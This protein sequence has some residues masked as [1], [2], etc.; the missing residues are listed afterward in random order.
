[1]IKNFGWKKDKFDE[2]DY[3][4]KPKVIKL[5]DK[6]SLEGY[7]PSV[8]DQGNLGSCTG[9]GIGGNLTGISKR[10]GMYTEWFS[11]VWIYNG[12]RLYGGTLGR[13]SGAYPRDC[14]E[15]LVDNGSLLEHFHPYSDKLDVTDPTKWAC[16]PEAK[17]YPVI[18]YTRIIGDE[19]SVCQALAEGH[20]VSLG[21]PWFYSWM[22]TDSKGNLPEDY[23]SVAGGHET[24]LYGYDLIDKVFYGQNS[25]GKE[26]GNNGKFTIPFSAWREFRK[27]GGWDAHTISVNWSEPPVPEPDDKP[28]FLKMLP[29]IGIGT[30]ILAFLIW[31]L[32]K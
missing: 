31:F 13:D 27:W 9:F 11:P 17:K 6:V 12:G 8:R 16:A 30:A 18:S 29:Y 21:C 15:F 4:F 22:N 2:R 24:L 14:L 23:T 3:I 25:W 28:E 7:C 10:L 26:W 5:P 1:M 20:L 19:T 32:T